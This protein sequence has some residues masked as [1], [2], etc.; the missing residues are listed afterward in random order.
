MGIFDGLAKRFGYVP[1]DPYTLIPRPPAKATPLTNPPAF[2]RADAVAEQYSIPDRSL[3]EAQLELYQRLT[4]VQIAVSTVAS[5]GATTAFNVLA[6]DGEETS[7][8]PNHPFELLLR[9]PNPLNSRAEFLEGTLSYY[10]LTGNAYWWLNKVG[11]TVAELWLLPPHKVTPVPDGRQYLRGYLYDTGNG[12]PIPLELSEVVHFRRFHPLNSFVGLSPIEALAVVATGDMAAQKWN[13]NFFDKDHAKLPGIL[14]F[15]DPIPDPDWERMG[16]EIKEQYGGVRRQLMRIRGAGKGGVEWISAAMSQADMQF[17]D[18]RTFTKEEIFAIYAPGLSSML[19]VNATEANSVSGKRTFIE[20]GVWPHL[21]RVAEKITNDLLPMYGP[22]LVGEFE[23]IRVTDKQL[24]LA[25]ISAYSQTHTVDE[26]RARYYQDEPLGDD[27]GNL[28]VTEVGKGLTPA[29]P[30]PEPPPAPIIMQPARQDTANQDTNDTEDAEDAADAAEPGDDAEDMQEGMND[31]DMGQMQAEGR[32]Q[33][34]RQAEVKALR[35]WLRNRGDKADPLKFKRVHLS[36]DDVMNEVLAMVLRGEVAMFRP[37]PIRRDTL[38]TGYNGGV[39]KADDQEADTVQPP[40]TWTD[41]N[42]TH[43]WAAVKA[44]VLQLDPGDD[45]AAERIIIELERRGETAILRAFREQW[46]NLLPPNAEDM[47]L[48]ELMAYVNARLIEQ[49]PAV[50]A[51][52]RVLYDAAGA[53][54]NV[55]LDQLDRIGIGFD[56]TLVNTRAQT[57]AQ[58]YAGELIRGINDTT[59]AAVR[60]AVERWY[61]N[62]E[63]LSALIDDLQPAFSKKRAKLIA[64]T[65]TTRAAAEGT[66]LGFRESGVVTGMVWKT[67]NDGERVC[68]IC[69]ELDGK[70]VSLDSGRFYDELPAEI[71]GKL[72]RTFEIP[73]SHPGCRCR[74]SAQVI[75]PAKSFANHQGRPGHVGGSLPRDAVAGSGN[76]QAFDNADDASSW[77]NS[78]FAEWNQSLT[79]SERRAFELYQSSEYRDLNA[80]LRTGESLDKD[81]KSLTKNLDAALDRASIDKDIVAYRGFSSQSY[82]DNFD[83]LAGT[84]VTDNGYISTSVDKAIGQKFAEYAL[85]EEFEPII[86]E[87][88]LPKGSKAAYINTLSLNENEVLIPRG[89]QFQVISTS[90]E[91]GVRTIVMEVLVG[92]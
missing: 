23:D 41:G 71:R 54:V 9:R 26:V 51:I 75:E 45:D 19:A 42:L 92:N 34:Q 17:L 62:G 40:F 1:Q 35:R 14:A 52:A 37:P 85:E 13:T 2:L 91:N 49:Q 33:R 84:I 73:P 29:D 61:G 68:P 64:Q 65:E 22:N 7:D 76:F 44:M 47:N 18:G 87:I 5:I 4:W 63:P 32:R 70:I 53:G 36:E 27:R 57:W 78:S 86:A 74:I 89:S 21:V 50:D 12:N 66:R 30:N 81:Q 58:Q 28:L 79:K 48:D 56:Y 24:E 6:L 20:Y 55:A 3:P 10:A 31:G 72:K 16:R 25:E 8:I 15:A 77:G 43:E 38:W 69:K 88:R 83:Q 39:I 80:A 11:N 82:I 90:T 60:Q 46:K 59:Q 67:V